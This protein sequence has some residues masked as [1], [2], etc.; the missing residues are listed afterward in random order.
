MTKDK[1]LLKKVIGVL[2]LLIFSFSFGTPLL[3]RVNTVEADDNISHATPYTRYYT[4]GT[5]GTN[6]YGVVYTESGINYETSY[7]DSYNPNSPHY[8]HAPTPLNPDD[9][10]NALADPDNPFNPGAP[11]LNPPDRDFIADPVHRDHPV[12][13]WSYQSESEYIHHDRDHW[14]CR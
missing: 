12:Y 3:I 13:E 5:P 7:G 6:S 4:C 11:N 1:V 2:S 14:R 9:I 10:L 8:D